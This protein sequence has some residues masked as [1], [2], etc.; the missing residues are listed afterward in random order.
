M[1][2][3]NLQTS[4]VSQ[5]GAIKER[6]AIWLRRHDFGDLTER[7]KA[8]FEKWLAE[9]DAHRAAYWRLKATWNET[10]RLSAL[11]RPQSDGVVSAPFWRAPALLFRLAAAAAVAVVVLGGAAV[12]LKDTQDKLYSTQ[13]GG[14]ETIRFADGTEIELNTNTVLRA[15]MTTRE[16]TVWLEKGEAFF[17][18]RHDAAN[19]MTVI[20]GER[21]IFDLG[22]QF[23][24][25]RSASELNVALFEGRVRVDKAN[26]FPGEEAVATPTSLLVSHKSVEDLTNEIAW[27]NGVLVFGKAT[28]ADAAKAFN[29]YNE[30]KL[31]VRDPAIANQIVGGTFRTNDVEGFISVVQELL[32]LRTAQSGNQIVIS[33]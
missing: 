19:P 7:D 27:R 23:L 13:I 2:E 18:V 29:R 16:R 28:L 21:R 10:Y 1:S 4:F 33:R 30:V 24:V 31:V 12:A 15:R 20:A 25:R 17:K 11:R 22:T 6:A 32:G 3:K 14:H 26:L 9:S 5:A 8:E